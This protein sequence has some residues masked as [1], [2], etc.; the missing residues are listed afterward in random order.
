MII[1]GS[2]L[3]R[4]AVSMFSRNTSKKLASSHQNCGNTFPEVLTARL[5]HTNIGS[6]QH[7][8]LRKV[9]LV[10]S[11]QSSSKLVLS[12]DITSLVFRKHFKSPMEHSLAQPVFSMLLS[13]KVKQKLVML[14]LYHN[15]I[16]LSSQL[17]QHVFFSS[18]FSTRSL[19]EIFKYVEFNGQHT[20][21]IN[22]VFEQ[23][24]DVASR[25]R[26]SD[27]GIESWLTTSKI[28]LRLLEGQKVDLF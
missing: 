16:E 6:I 17:M 13:T 22:Q 3:C 7:S 9:M 4:N 21:K 25:S 12:H 20:Q 19:L 14:W 24:K 15:F 26:V 1:Y 11:S 10:L 18:I 27:V 23:H 8:Y 28:S 2:R 5:K